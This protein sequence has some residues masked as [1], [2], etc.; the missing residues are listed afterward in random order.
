[1]AVE[2]FV[3]LL[4]WPGPRANCWQWSPLFFKPD[5][6]SWPLPTSRVQPQW[7]ASGLSRTSDTVAVVHAV[8][9][10]GKTFMRICWE[11]R[12]FQLRLFI[13]WSGF[14]PKR[15]PPTGTFNVKLGTG[16]YLPPLLCNLTSNKNILHICAPQ[17]NRRGFL[18]SLTYPCVSHTVWSGFSA[19]TTLVILSLCG[20]TKTVHSDH[21]LSHLQ[22][23]ETVKS[24]L[25]EVLVPL[26]EYVCM[27]LEWKL[28]PT[29]SRLYVGMKGIFFNKLKIKLWTALELCLFLNFKIRWYA[30]N[31]SRSLS[32]CYWKITNVFLKL[33]CNLFSVLMQNCHLCKLHVSL[34]FFFKLK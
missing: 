34:V 28:W 25:P 32:F 5:G 11:V 20:P 4:E 10:G 27:T 14:W 19:V 17:T 23:F 33:L 26:T 16:Y 13:I 29:K 3:I 6:S 22:V 21:L 2:F 18:A 1:M 7:P 24:Q 15:A 31:C 9:C 8:G 12:L 30:L